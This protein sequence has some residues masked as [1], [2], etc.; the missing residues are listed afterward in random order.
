MALL[1]ASALSC[2]ERRYETLK[3][4]KAAKTSAAL[5][6]G[7]LGGGGITPFELSMAIGTN[8]RVKGA[9]SVEAVQ[10]NRYLAPIANAERKIRE[11]EERH[12]EQEARRE[13]RRS[14]TEAKQRKRQERASR[15]IQRAYRC[16]R[17]R[18][19]FATFMTQRE[20][21]IM[22]QCRWR[23]ILFRRRMREMLIEQIR[24]ACATRLQAVT[25]GG[26][27][28]LALRRKRQLQA[29]KEL[30]LKQ[31]LQARDLRK[32]STAQVHVAYIARVGMRPSAAQEGEADE[33]YQLT[34]HN[35][36]RIYSAVVIQ[37]RVRGWLGRRRAANE[38][39]S[40]QQQFEL[41]LR[42]VG[43]ATVIQRA[44]RNWRRWSAIHG[45]R[46]AALPSGYLAAANRLSQS[47]SYQSGPH[48]DWEEPVSD[49]AGR[50]VAAMGADIP[51]AEDSELFP[52]FAALQPAATVSRQANRQASRKA[53]RQARQ[54]SLASGV[55]G[56]QHRTQSCV[57]RRGRRGTDV[58]DGPDDSPEAAV[59][60]L[61]RM[62]AMQIR[63]IWLTPD[64]GPEPGEDGSRRRRSNKKRAGTTVVGHKET[65]MA[66]H[67]FRKAQP[68]VGL[69]YLQAAMI[70]HQD[71]LGAAGARG[72]GVQAAEY[73][74]A[75]NSA[76]T[77][78]MLS[79]PPIL[80]FDEAKELTKRAMESL[81]SHD[82]TAMLAENLS[83]AGLRRLEHAA[84]EHNLA[85][86]D[87]VSSP[88]RE[89]WQHLE[90]A[91]ADVDS[92]VQDCPALR[93]NMHTVAVHRT[94]TAMKKVLAAAAGATHAQH[95][96]P[97]SGAA[98]MTNERDNQCGLLESP[99]EEPLRRP[100]TSRHNAGST[101]SGTGHT[102][103][104]SVGVPSQP[105][106]S[107][108]DIRSLAGV[109]DSSSASQRAR[110][111]AGA[112]YDEVDDHMNEDDDVQHRRRANRRR[113]KTAPGGRRGGPG[114]QSGHLVSFADSFVHPSSWGH[115][116]SQLA[117]PVKLRGMTAPNSSDLMDAAAANAN[118]AA[119]AMAMAALNPATLHT[120]VDG[121][122]GLDRRAVAV[123]MPSVDHS[124]SSVTVGLSSPEMG[125]ARALGRQRRQPHKRTTAPGSDS[126]TI[127]GHSRHYL[128]QMALVSRRMVA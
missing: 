30:R 91:R 36:D 90:Q 99:L 86:L 88:G 72:K 42:Q 109:L 119:A 108:V 43:A 4:E 12:K 29:A 94:Y 117:R 82:D 84:C 73:A 98:A 80:K 124:A 22:V 89:T 60:R 33:D 85:L 97:S 83:R 79:L 121:R 49:P 51:V 68:L 50:A 62:E 24:A 19:Q 103:L 27:V 45:L 26:L 100:T 9:Q 87:L 111:A 13:A 102:R 34:E 40:L 52:L 55:G 74:M 37:A 54:P 107:Q 128:D 95:D 6:G 122:R 77:A 115:A 14:R 15:K 125:T 11:R 32:K 66:R 58:S 61:R 59:E 71:A 65:E 92:A 5:F 28:R 96:Q 10:E 53:Y 63:L 69:R 118:A 17:F 123:G 56:R 3:K 127:G 76:N 1:Q 48:A 116:H 20:A 31:E 106:M 25:R 39:L 114:V 46:S 21:V 38:M 78:C 81:A 8:V 7:E 126:L 110:L 16:H 113:Q 57:S 70:V 47:A 112:P 18:V 93:G 75:V 2:L 35:Y 23:G 41:C 44:W 120:T 101:T 105:D 104:P 64:L 67:F